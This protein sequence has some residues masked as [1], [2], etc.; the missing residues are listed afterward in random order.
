MHVTEDPAEAREAVRA[1]QRAGK[2]VGL[3]PTMG[4]LHAGHL[5]LVTASREVADATA[6]TIFVNPTQFGPQEDFARYPRTLEADLE[7]LREA[8][9]DLVFVP[10]RETM[11]PPGY[12]TYVEP[13][14]IANPFEGAL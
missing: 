6:A 3:V 13:P 12:S 9:T 2:R 8:G 10:N 11:Y 7:K 4:A 1:L 5:S 14:E